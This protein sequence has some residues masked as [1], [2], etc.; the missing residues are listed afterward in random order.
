[1]INDAYKNLGCAVVLSLAKWF[2]ENG[3]SKS[4]KQTIIKDLK[5]DYMV[6]FS[7]GW[8]LVV[9]EQLKKNPKEIAMRLKKYK[10]EM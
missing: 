2:F 9:A 3:T 6:A 8:S 4:R 10:E 7:D 5:S 1:M